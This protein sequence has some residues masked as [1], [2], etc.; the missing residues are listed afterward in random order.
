MQD[1]SSMLQPFESLLKLREVE[2]TRGRL[3]FFDDPLRGVACD[4]AEWEQEEQE[5]EAD[6]ASKPLFLFLPGFD[7]TG[8]SAQS[9]FEDLG[10][11]YVVRR[12]QYLSQDRSNFDELVRFVCSYV[13][14]WRESRRRRREKDAGVFLLGESFGG[15][16]ALAVALQLEEEE[17]GAVA[18]LVLANPASSFLRSDWPLTSQLITELPAALPF[19][20]LQLSQLV[21]PLRDGL[22]GELRSSSLLNKTLGSLSY[23]SLG[24]SL[25]LTR[26]LDMKTA[27]DL[28]EGTRNRLQT[29]SQSLLRGDV[30]GGIADLDSSWALDSLLSILPE[31]TVRHRLK[32]YLE[33]G[34]RKRERRRRREGMRKRGSEGAR[35]KRSENQ[36]LPQ[37]F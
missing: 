34:K 21:P 24:S 7:G 16:L 27:G 8:V 14:G 1:R 22:L 23:A 10:R 3:L 19:K 30:A 31:D 25:L 36:N 37:S 20:D 15:L 13:R 28:L 32:F 9:Q 26:A 5:E 4:S 35:E 2:K 29:L 12:M 33:Q 17:Q 11:T 18:G 6:G